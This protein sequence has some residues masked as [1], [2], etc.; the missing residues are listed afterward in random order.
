M[1]NGIQ[2]IQEGKD[3][4]NKPLTKSQRTL[5]HVLGDRKRAESIIQMSTKWQKCSDRDAVE[6]VKHRRVT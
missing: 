4:F 6:G 2:E 1:D 5:T 3:K